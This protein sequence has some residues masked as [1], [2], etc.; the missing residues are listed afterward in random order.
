MATA[1]RTAVPAPTEGRGDARRDELLDAAVDAIRTIGPDVT[2][3]QIAAAAGVTKP[4]VYRHVGDKADVTR[5][6]AE[7]YLDELLD[8]L[9][10]GLAATDDPRERIAATLDAYLTLVEEDPAIYRFLVQGA[11]TP[12]PAT[13]ATVTGFLRRVADRITAVLRGEFERFGLDDRGVEAIA[14][15]LVGM[16]QLAGDWWVD[17]AALTRAELVDRLTGWVWG[18]FAGL[19]RR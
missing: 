1:E 16:T 10:A 15:G 7:R 5:L 17:Q 13:Q 11:G 9:E 19:P 3:A 4:I 8:R 2:M 6:L 14:Y 18:G 12:D